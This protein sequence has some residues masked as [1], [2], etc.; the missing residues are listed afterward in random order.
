MDLS[1]IRK[2]P[3]NANVDVLVAVSPENFAY[4]SGA[5]VLTVTTIRPRLAFAVL[6]ADGEAASIVC[7][8]E[9]TTMLDESWIEDIRLY[10]EFVDDPVDALCDALSDMGKTSG[11]LGIDLSYLPQTSYE[12]LVTRLP[13]FEIVDTTDDVAAVRA[14]KSDAEI[15]ILEKAAK[16]THRAIVRGMAQSR[17]GD[18]EKHMCDKIL[19]ELIRG[20]AVSIDFVCFASGERTR[21]PH[22]Q[23]NNRVPEESE[24]IRFDLG[25]EF[26]QWTSDMARTYS[27]GNPTQ[28]QREVYRLLCEAQEATIQSV[29]PGLHAEDIY[30]TCKSEFEKRGLEWWLPHVGHSFGIELHEKPMLRPGDK[31]VLKPGMVFNIEPLVFDDKQIGYHTEDLLAVTDE[32]Y[33]LLTYELAPKELPVIG[34]PVS[35]VSP[36]VPE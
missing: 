30:Y 11:K 25:G 2:L 3:G 22:A 4:V 33:R 32:G 13:D 14:L 1:R 24:I 9:K 17:L 29:R 21:M 35:Q 12:R 31:T 18:T 16:I 23:P 19:V 15:D 6:T 26:G 8:I 7:S 10:T 28:Q 36:A 20:G 5:Y 34:Q 27:T